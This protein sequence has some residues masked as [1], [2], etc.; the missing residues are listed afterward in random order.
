MTKPSLRL[1]SP[2]SR[3]R[4]VVAKAMPTRKPNSEYR[5]R[6]H[7]AEHEVKALIASAK[8]NRWGHRDAT[9]ILV[10][11]RHGQRVSEVCDLEWAEVD[12]KDGTL[13]L[14]RAKGGDPGTHY[15]QGDEMRALRTLKRDQEERQIKSRYVFISERG[16]PFTRAGVAKMIE[17]AGEAAKLPFPVHA[18]MLRHACGYAL[19]SRGV[20]T[21]TLQAYLG[22][23]S[24][25]STTRYAAIAPGRFKNIWAK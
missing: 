3:L 10:M 4:T 6:E 5:P 15:L 14:R 2:A 9:M 17:R 7:L 16:D 22:H 8:K 13:N 12:F 24:I 25:H 11:W 21:R 19:A 20:D 18:H 1:V 23:K